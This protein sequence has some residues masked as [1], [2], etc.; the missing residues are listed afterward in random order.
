MSEPLRFLHEH[1]D[2]G[3][4]VDL[5]SRRTG[6]AQALIEKDYWVTHALAALQ[7]AGLDVWFKGGTSLSKGFGLIKRFSEDLDLKVE[8]G[9]LPPV[10]SWKSEKPAS[11]DE[12]R[13]FFAA[14]ASLPLPSLTIAPDDDVADDK[15]RGMN[16]RAVYPIT[17]PDGSGAIRPHVLLELGD[18]RVT[19]FVDVKMTSFVADEAKAA[20]VPPGYVV[21][22]PTV[23][24][25]HPLVT[26]LEKLDALSRRVPKGKPAPTFVRHYE[27]AAWI[28]RAYRAGQ[29]PALPDFADARALMT[30][31]K[32]TKDIANVPASTDAA[33]NIDQLTAQR[34][35][36]IE[37]AHEA[38]R[39]L[40]W[41]E[42]L[43]LD[44]ACREIREFIDDVTAAPAIL[45]DA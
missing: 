45:H 43:S 10:A 40:F 12:R 36:E 23:R 29:L 44:V 35:Q 9:A 15:L 18:A 20:G 24:C 17:K 31:M 32:R 5:A 11:I 38:I 16:L 28:A 13:R 30:E 3:V 34:R 21:T 1:P 7:A 6:I 8:G 22:T 27:D 41:G 19:P 25:V 4:L 14:V 42:R 26:L 39:P 2:F 33:F 37:A